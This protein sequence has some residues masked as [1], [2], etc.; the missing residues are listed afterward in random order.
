VL[1]REDEVVVLGREE[2]VTVLGGG[3]GDAGGGGRVEQ[4]GYDGWKIEMRERRE[5]PLV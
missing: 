2:E 3:R 4:R 1:G 5:N